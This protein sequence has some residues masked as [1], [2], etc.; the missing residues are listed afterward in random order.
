MQYQW[1][2]AW[3][4]CVRMSKSPL[5]TEEDLCGKSAILQFRKAP[6]QEDKSCPRNHYCSDS[7][8][9]APSI[10]KGTSPNHHQSLWISRR[11]S[12]FTCSL[13]QIYQ[14]YVL[15]SVV[16]FQFYPSYLFS[17]PLDSL[18]LSFSSTSFPSRHFF[19]WY[20][21]CEI[22]LWAFFVHPIYPL[23]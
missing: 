10:D 14:E 3:L 1:P 18:I 8:S 5:S 4:W 16:H 11:R 12:Q 22:G 15:T 21:K 23:L 17:H 13:F 20:R 7:T 2:V 6:V 9:F 19:F